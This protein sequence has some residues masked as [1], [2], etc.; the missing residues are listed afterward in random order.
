MTEH[1]VLGGNSSGL[2]S[3]HLWMLFPRPYYKSMSLV[4]RRG[5]WYAWHVI[6]LTLH[7]IRLRPVVRGD[8]HPRN[9]N[10]EAER[11]EL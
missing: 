7:F 1:L 9:P 6:M 11:Y 8:T 2:V 10:E 5:Q 4:G 3:F